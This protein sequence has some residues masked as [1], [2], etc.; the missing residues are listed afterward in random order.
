MKYSVEGQL[1]INKNIAMHREYDTNGGIRSSGHTQWV[2]CYIAH[3]IDLDV[4]L[5]QIKFITA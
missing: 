1:A 4:H 3:F 5:W 2:L